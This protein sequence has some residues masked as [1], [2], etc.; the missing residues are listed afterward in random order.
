MPKHKHANDIFDT[1]QRSEQPKDD[2]IYQPQKKSAF[3]S[4]SLLPNYTFLKQYPAS[5]QQVKQVLSA[6]KRTPFEIQDKNT[7]LQTTLLLAQKTLKTIGIN[8]E[9]Q[10]MPV[11]TVIRKYQSFATLFSGAKSPKVQQ[12]ATF[13]LAND[14]FFH[15]FSPKTYAHTQRLIENSRNAYIANMLYAIMWHNLSRKG[16]LSW[17]ANTLKNLYHESQ[18]G[19]EIVYIAGGTDFYQLLKHGIFSIRII[20]PFFPTQDTYYSAGW[21][22]LVGGRYFENIGDTITLPCNNTKLIL[23]RIA[24]EKTGATIKHEQKTIP[25]SITQWRIFKNTLEEP[26]GTLTLDRRFVT[27][28][29]FLPSPKRCLLISVN[30]LYF[31]TS[32]GSASWGISLKDIDPQI[33]LYVKQLRNP[34]SKTIMRNMHTADKKGY[35][36]IQLGSCVD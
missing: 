36:F 20:D 12:K 5:Y 26:V 11:T 24:Y 10:S 3:K 22:F 35:G 32:A 2:V 30:E 33:V 15:T 34:V 29:D 27:N 14:I 17:H 21:R 16:W 19:K 9:E 7:A 1:W 6:C 8:K 23:Q 31:I 4:K 28:N 18:Q 25:C 13:S